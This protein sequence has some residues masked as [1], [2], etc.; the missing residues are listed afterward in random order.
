MGSIIGAAV[1]CVARSVIHKRTVSG[2]IH[3]SMA[4]STLSGQECGFIVKII[5]ANEMPAAAA[6]WLSAG[7]PFDCIE[8]IM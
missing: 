8:I 5:R 2:N 7:L 1:A 4:Y 6:E 3:F